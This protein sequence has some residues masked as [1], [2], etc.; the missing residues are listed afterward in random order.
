RS[1]L[2]MM[3]PFTFTRTCSMMSPLDS[4][5][6]DPERVDGSARRPATADVRITTTDA[7][8]SCFV[9]VFNILPY[10]DALAQ[11]PQQ[12]GHPAEYAPSRARILFSGPET[13]PPR[14]PAGDFA[15]SGS[16]RPP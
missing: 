1:V 5:R 3:S 6:D 9:I 8:K 10:R 16:C 13:P 7:T 11:I 15:G 14:D 2:L 12:A 4:A